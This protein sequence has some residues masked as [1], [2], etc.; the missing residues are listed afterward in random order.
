MEIFRELVNEETAKADGLV[1]PLR[2]PPTMGRDRGARSGAGGCRLVPPGR[3]LLATLLDLQAA[4]PVAE[5]LTQEQ[6]DSALERERAC[7]R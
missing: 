3:R 1:S 4:I 2:R 6:I 7:A 5:G